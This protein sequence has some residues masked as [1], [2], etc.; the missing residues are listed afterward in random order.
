MHIIVRLMG[1]LCQALVDK[2][3]QLTARTQGDRGN[4]GIYYRRTGTGSSGDMKRE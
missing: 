2:A 1:S 3:F 4:G